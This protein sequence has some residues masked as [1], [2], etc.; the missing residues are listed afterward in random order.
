MNGILNT[1]APYVPLAIASLMFISL[2]L[3]GWLA[4]KSARDTSARHRE[5]I[6]MVH[7]SQE[8]QA[9]ASSLMRELIIELRAARQA[10]DA[11]P[12]T[13]KSSN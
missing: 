1:D 12:S 10:P 6:A 9:E 3:L 2:W 8:L 7:S 4:W 5:W 11:P 13:E